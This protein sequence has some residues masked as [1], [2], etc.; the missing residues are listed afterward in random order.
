MALLLHQMTRRS[1]SERSPYDVVWPATVVAALKKSELRWQADLIVNFVYTELAFDPTEFGVY[2]R[3]FGGAKREGE[4]SVIQKHFYVIY[5]L[6][7]STLTVMDVRPRHDRG[8][9]PGRR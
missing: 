7:G 3:K 6:K 8:T 1:G 2:G 5:E 9:R 4:Y